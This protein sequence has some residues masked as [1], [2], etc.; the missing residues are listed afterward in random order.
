MTLSGVGVF[1]ATLGIDSGAT[2]IP[3]GGAT[4]TLKVPPKPLIG[5]IE[6]L[7]EPDEPAVRTREGGVS[8]IWKSGAAVTATMS[9]DVRG[10][11]TAA[12]VP[13]KTPPADPVADAPAVT[14]NVALPPTGIV[15]AGGLKEMP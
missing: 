10:P 6:T 12:E 15:A 1:A 7:E 8:W 3:A 2:V 5:T 13:L 9:V 11:V 14:V 4:E